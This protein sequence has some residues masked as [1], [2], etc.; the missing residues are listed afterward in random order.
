MKTVDSRKGIES[1]I[2]P[3]RVFYYYAVAF[4]VVW[5]IIITGIFTTV[6]LMG[7]LTK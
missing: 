4:V 7:R 3:V 2:N 5:A 6:W 1:G